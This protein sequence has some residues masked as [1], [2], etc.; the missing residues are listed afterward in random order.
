MKKMQYLKKAVFVTVMGFLSVTTTVMANEKTP[1]GSKVDS[2]VRV[3]YI[4]VQN[5]LPVVE[6]QLNGAET[7]DYFV[8][9]KDE[10]G[11]LLFS[12]KLSGTKITRKYIL[13]SEEIEV[14]GTTFEITNR[15]TNETNVYK[16]LRQVKQEEILSVT[17]VYSAR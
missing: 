12:E 17:K 2:N 11:V 15:K 13:Q 7:T 1:V 5:N 9:V 16:V 3:S 6:L 14:A 4:G 8:N 10:N